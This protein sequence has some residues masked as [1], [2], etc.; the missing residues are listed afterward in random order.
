MAVAKVPSGSSR[1]GDSVDI[2]V[3]GFGTVG[4][5]LQLF[6]IDG[7]SP[8]SDILA[9]HDN[10]LGDFTFSG[11]IIPTFPTTAATTFQC[12]F[13]VVDLSNMN[14]EYSDAFDLLAA[15]SSGP[16]KLALSTGL[17]L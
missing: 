11:V 3:T 5:T 2:V 14:E 6:L 17:S 7:F 13:K 4:E 1:I 8:D 15:V 12:Q 9:D 16:R 10:Y